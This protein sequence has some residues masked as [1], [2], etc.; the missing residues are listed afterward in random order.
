MLFVRLAGTRG[1]EDPSS[2]RQ[3]ED[4]EQRRE[5]EGGSTSH[6]EAGAGSVSSSRARVRFGSIGMPG[7]MVVLMVA[8]RM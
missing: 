2:C 3:R 5:D 8:L 6:Y 1:V 7:P 4:G